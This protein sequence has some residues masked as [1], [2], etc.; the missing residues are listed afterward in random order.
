MFWKRTTWNVLK[1]RYLECSPP[2]FISVASISFFGE[3]CSLIFFGLAS[4]LSD[5]FSGIF[6]RSPSSLFGEF[7]GLNSREERSALS[8][9]GD[10][11]VLRSREELLRLFVRFSFLCF[12]LDTLG[13][14]LRRSLPT[15]RSLFFSFLAWNNSLLSNQPNSRLLLWS[16]SNQVNSCVFPPS[17]GLPFYQLRLSK[18][19]FKTT[20]KS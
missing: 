11:T 18:L 13:L 1:M 2:L 5:G 17:R 3:L 6:S 7:R 16:A 4:G 15:L 14:R 12:F 10:F 20:M 19:P 9:I 8:F